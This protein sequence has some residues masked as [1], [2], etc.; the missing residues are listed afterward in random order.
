MQSEGKR[1]PGTPKKYP[2]AVKAYS[3]I[4][5]CAPVAC[6]MMPCLISMMQLA[7]AVPRQVVEP[8]SR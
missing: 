1:P 6:C 7:T 4:I 3:I 8:D 5:K 2:N